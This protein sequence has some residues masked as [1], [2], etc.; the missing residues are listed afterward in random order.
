MIKNVTTDYFNNNVYDLQKL[1]QFNSETDTLKFLGKKPLVIDFH[2]K[3]CGP[4]KMLSPI[5]DEL[6]EYYD[7]KIDFYKIDIE[8][9]MELAQIF[10][11]QSVPTL[12]FIPIGGKPSVQPGAPSKDGMKEIIDS[13][14]LNKKVEE[15]ED[16][17]TTFN[18]IIE[19][20]RRFIN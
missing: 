20:I 3:W 4:C 12:L 2:A 19:K 5:I 15:K 6:D 14:L 1:E 8:D 11:V 18:K 13:A 16:P 10:G 7:G 17:I 9:E